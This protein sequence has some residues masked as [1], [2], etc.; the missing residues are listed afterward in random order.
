MYVVLICKVDELALEVVV[1]A[2]FQT[3]GCF[4][5][6]LLSCESTRNNLSEVILALLSGELRN[7]R[8]ALTF[9]VFECLL[10]DVITSY[11]IRFF[12]SDGLAIQISVDDLRSL[13]GVCDSFYCDADLVITAVAASEYAFQS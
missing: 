13:S 8:T 10:G 5:L 12:V 4:F 1:A 3:S 11:I 9:S 6:S 2:A 7:L